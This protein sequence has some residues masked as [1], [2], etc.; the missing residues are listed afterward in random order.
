MNGIKGTLR[1]TK[2]NR[3]SHP[4]NKQKNE[5]NITIEKGPKPTSTP[6][7]NNES[8]LLQCTH[9]LRQTTPVPAD[10]PRA[11]QGTP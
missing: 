9:L 4:K 2:P 7:K 10:A 8:L 5:E 1:A 3:R 11:K 6:S